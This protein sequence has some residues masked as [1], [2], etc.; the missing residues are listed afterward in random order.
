MI[1]LFTWLPACGLNNQQVEFD[2]TTDPKRAETKIENNSNNNEDLK[3]NNP[4]V[5]AAA[6]RF[7]AFSLQADYNGTEH[8]INIEYEFDGERIDAIYKDK[9]QDI[10]LYSFGAFEEL[11]DK[12][13]GFNFTEETPNEDVVKTV[14]EAFHI[15]EDAINIEL[16]ITF[17]VGVEKEYT[18]IN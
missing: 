5:K 2:P 12:F 13:S 8:A 1:I 17:N 10:N 14:I 18:S 15:P 4:A 3:P 6:Y 9:N 11:D 16:E 7:K